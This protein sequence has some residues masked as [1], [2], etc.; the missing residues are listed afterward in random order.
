MKTLV[1]DDD[2]LGCMLLTTFFEDFGSCDQ[3]E[4]GKA[5]LDLYEVAVAEENPYDLICLDIVMPVMDGMTTLCNLREREQQN[6]RKRTMVFIISARG[7]ISD[8]ED[9]F[10]EGDC[11]D[12]IV[13]PFSRESVRQMLDR[14]KMILPE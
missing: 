14:H 11:D 2:E 13:K 10:F 6:K 8:I 12:Y 5:A 7:S 3:A 4:N 1:V 9:A